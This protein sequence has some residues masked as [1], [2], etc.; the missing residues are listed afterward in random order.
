MHMRITLVLI[1]LLFSL[2]TMAQELNKP[3]FHMLALGDSYTIGE[4]VSAPLRW[5]A[6]LIDSL[7]KARKVN[8]K[9]DIVAK[10]GWRTDDLISAVA[11]EKLEPKYDLVSLCIG[12]NNQYQ[13]KPISQYEREFE[14]LLKT[15]I[16]LADSSPEK[17]IV[18]SIP[19]YAYTPFGKG[20]SNISK[21]IDAYNA[22]AQG[23]CSRYGVRF[24]DITSISRLGLLQTNLVASDALHPSAEQ[25]GKWVIKV[26]PF[27]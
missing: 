1:A 22:I 12:V 11:S 14:V 13:H 19:D 16:A 4:S 15:A 8:A 25:Y 3:S 6:Q 24:I 18:L 9:Y 7:N 5:P 26:L 21:E 10:T 20:D 2:N 27:L 17:T 23:I